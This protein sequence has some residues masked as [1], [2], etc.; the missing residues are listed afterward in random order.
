VCSTK[1][2]IRKVIGRAYLS[3]PEV[4]TILAEI[5]FAI[6]SRPYFSDGSVGDLM[7]LTPFQLITGYQPTNECSFPQPTPSVNTCTKDALIMRDQ[8]MRR[9]LDTFWLRWKKDYIADCLRFRA[10]GRLTVSPRLNKFV[11]VHDANAKRIKWQTAIITG[12]TKEKDGHTRL[13]FLRT[14]TG[15]M[16]N[17][18]VQILYPLELDE[19]VE[20]PQQ[21]KLAILP[22]PGITKLPVPTR[23][24][25]QVFDSRHW[26]TA[27]DAVSVPPDSSVAVSP[28]GAV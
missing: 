3:F 21:D 25:P 16:M 28:M 12:L 8:R 24:K 1:E 13:A 11:L 22:P 27:P 26:F 4:D 20:D 23:K 7:P 10:P 19:R 18:P 15:G 9:A 14:K 6:N 5:S 17:R 2:H